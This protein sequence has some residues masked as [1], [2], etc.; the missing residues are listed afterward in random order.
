MNGNET[1]RTSP[2]ASNSLAAEGN[3]LTESTSSKRSTAREA[4]DQIFRRALLLYQRGRLDEA[5]QLYQ[6]ILHVD[7]NHFASL[8]QLGL[9]RAQQGRLE[10]AITL[11]R[12][13]I[14]QNPIFAD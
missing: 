2:P 14:D 3:W 9:I 13:A 8:H 5:E 6:G 4:A 11:F 7:P 10:E 12:E 1:N